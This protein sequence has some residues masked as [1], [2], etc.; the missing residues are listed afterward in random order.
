MLTFEPLHVKH[1]EY[2]SPMSVQSDEL[3][4]L[5]SPAG[6]EALEGSLSLSAWAQG[7]CLGAAGI[8]RP[9]KGRGE[10]WTLLSEGAAPY[11]LPIVRKMRQVIN[12]QTDLVRVD[13]MVRPGNKQGAQFARLLGFKKEAVLR[14]YH[15]SGDDLIVFARVKQWPS[16]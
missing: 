4:Y 2:I 5:Y 14:R 3:A 15:P 6:R 12:E 7:R 10:A 13:M 1:F 16:H 11:L 8:N 9:W